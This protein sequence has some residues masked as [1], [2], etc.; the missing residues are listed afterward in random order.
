M[1]YIITAIL[2]WSSLGVFIRLSALPASSLIF[3]PCVVSL[4]PLGILMLRRPHGQLPGR[5]DLA[6]LALLGGLSLANTGTFYLAY[7][8]TTVANAVLTHYT[9]PVLV[10]ILAP[11]MLKERLSL[12]IIAAVAL[13]ASGLGI[14]LGVSPVQFAASLLSGDRDSYGIAAG[15]ASG[16]SYAFVIIVTRFGAQRMDPMMMTLGQNLSVSV[17]LLPIVEVPQ[18]LFPAVWFLIVMGILHSTVAP[19]LYFRGMKEV[20][21]NKAAILGY[22]EPVSAIILGAVVL[23]EPVGYATVFGGCMILLSGYLT[24]RL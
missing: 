14:M 23:G 13:A 21:A 8:N 11:F 2:L 7:Q 15:L 17:L 22:L 20:T 12:S 10:A 19:T 18:P 6:L 3:F 1:I 5:D 24:R 4:L 16:L 9:A